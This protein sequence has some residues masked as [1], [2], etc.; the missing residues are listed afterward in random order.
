MAL[1]DITPYAKTNN[2]AGQKVQRNQFAT[3]DGH[4][5]TPKEAI[6]IDEYIKTGNALRSAETA[7]YS[8]KSYKGLSQKAQRILNKDY[9]IG[10]INFRLEQRRDESIADATEIMQYFTSVMRGEINDQFGIE[11]PL[12]ERTKAAQELAK[13]QIDLVAK[14]DSGDVPKL[15]ITVDWGED[16]SANLKTVGESIDSKAIQKEYDAKPQIKDEE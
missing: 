9:I 5:L 12:S 10:E 11:A 13:R 16:A 15:T 1:D 2:R 3:H 14:Q 7:G 8:S 4:A 6:F